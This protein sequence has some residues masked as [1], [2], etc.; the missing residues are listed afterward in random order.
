M[1][2]HLLHKLL[3]QVSTY[4]VPLPGKRR[5]VRIELLHEIQGN[6]RNTRGDV[7]EHPASGE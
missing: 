2:D 1:L 7:A 3:Q 6:Q 4:P 5:P